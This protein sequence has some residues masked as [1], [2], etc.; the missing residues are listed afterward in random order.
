MDGRYLCWVNLHIN[1]IN[2]INTNLNLLGDDGIDV[3][4]NVVESSSLSPNR[5][6]YGNLHNQGHN[7]ISFVHDPDQKYLEEYGVMGDVTTAMRDPIFYVRVCV[8]KGNVNLQNLFSS[9]IFPEMA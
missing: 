8:A 1:E 4:G 5:L 2:Y 6:L 3:L 7:I 9:S